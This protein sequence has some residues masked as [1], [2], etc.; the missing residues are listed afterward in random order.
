MKL[1]MSLTMSFLFSI[2]L[3]QEKNLKTLRMGVIST[4]LL[5]NNRIETLMSK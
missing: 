4:M 3:R 5:K 2:K 1:A